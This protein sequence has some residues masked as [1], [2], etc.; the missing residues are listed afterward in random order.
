[1]P[2]AQT[3]PDTTNQIQNR[4]KLSINDDPDLFTIHLLLIAISPYVHCVLMCCL[5]SARSITAIQF[6]ASHQPTQSQLLKVLIAPSIPF[7]PTFT[8]K[9]FHLLTNRFCFP[10]YSPRSYNLPWSKII[11]SLERSH[12]YQGSSSRRQLYLEDHR[13]TR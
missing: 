8:S 4:T 9:I 3:P 5:L 11:W 6:Y 7:I 1:M 10:Y 12:G 2:I 13:S